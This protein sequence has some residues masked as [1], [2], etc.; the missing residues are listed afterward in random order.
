MNKCLLFSERKNYFY[1]INVS[2]VMIEILKVF[3]S[4]QSCDISLQ[5]SPL[6]PGCEGVGD[7]DGLHPTPKTTITLNHTHTFMID[8]Q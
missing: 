8:L 2:Q 6:P 7:G 3:F 4:R 5:G 1:T